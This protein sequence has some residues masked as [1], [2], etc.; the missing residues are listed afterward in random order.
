MALKLSDFGDPEL[1]KIA[2]R[3]ERKLPLIEETERNICNGRPTKSETGERVKLHEVRVEKKKAEALS[4]ALASEP[5]AH[6]ADID[7]LA[8]EALIGTST[9]IVSIE[10]LEQ[11][12]LARRAVGRI[13]GDGFGSFGTGFHVGLGLVMTNHHVLPDEATASAHVFEMNY[14]DNKFGAPLRP[15]S[16]QFDPGRFFFTNKEHDVT[17]VAATD[18]VGTNPPL[19]SYGW[20]VLIAKQGKILKGQPV[21]IIQHPRGRPKAVVVHNSNFLHLENETEDDIYCWYSGDTEKG[22]SGS[23]VFNRFWEVVALHHKAVPR[24]NDRGEVLDRNGRTLSVERARDNPDLIA[25]VANEG[26]RAS[27]LI[28]AI[29]A[30]DRFPNAEMKK[31]RDDLLTHWSRPGA[32][33]FALK[34]ALQ[35]ETEVAVV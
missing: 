31:L 8:Q 2:R 35:P 16:Y 20:H 34:A 30:Y 25:Y 4:T 12:M 24:T 1:E 19:E 33:A 13:Q 14:E 9:N 32:A 18:F 7:W 29:T 27:R 22:S 23:P 5:G 28:A 21:N 26:I 10:F 6:A 11:G 15:Y 17:V 3:V